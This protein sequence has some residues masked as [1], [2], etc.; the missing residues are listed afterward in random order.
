MINSS[1]R[2]LLAA[3]GMLSLL[4]YAA[5]LEAHVGGKT[6]SAADKS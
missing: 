1:H 3:I 5:D 6:P 2:P 4:D